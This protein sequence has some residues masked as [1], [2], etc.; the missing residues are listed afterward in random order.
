M[1]AEERLIPPVKQ[2]LAE[3]I[4]GEEWRAIAARA[5]KSITIIRRHCFRAVRNGEATLEQIRYR[6]TKLKGLPDAAYNERWLTRV[7]ANCK[8]D[9][10][11][12]WLWT[13][14]IHSIWGY[15]YTAYRGYPK[16]VHRQM[17]KVT[18]GV[19]L[20]RDQYVCHTCDVRHCVNPDHLWLGSNSDNQKDSSQKGRH[21]ESRRACCESGHEFTPENTRIRP[22]KSGGVARICKQCEREKYYSAGYRQVLAERRRISARIKRG[23]SPDEAKNKPPRVWR[24]RE[25]NVR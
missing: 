13:G 1:L 8:V 7:R 4:A 20:A 3:R 19:E 23:W 22:T 18:H 21:Y 6:P 11:G 5:G 15:A 17:Y 12:C 14:V 24:R 25:L 16:P 2:W 10:S 9:D